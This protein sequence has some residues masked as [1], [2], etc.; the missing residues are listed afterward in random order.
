MDHKGPPDRVAPLQEGKRMAIGMLAAARRRDD[1]GIR[2]LMRDW[3][4]DATIAL[5]AFTNMVLDQYLGEEKAAEFIL[6]TARAV[7]EE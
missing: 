2:A 6:D 3:D 1:V 4:S 7:S 5:V